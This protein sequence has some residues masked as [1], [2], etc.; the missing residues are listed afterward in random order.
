MERGGVTE[1]ELYVRDDLAVCILEAEDV[2]AYLETIDGDEAVEEGSATSPSSNTRASTST[3]R[4]NRSC[5]WSASGRS[6]TIRPRNRQQDLS[7]F[8]MTR[9]YGQTRD[10]EPDQP[11]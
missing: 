7:S 1:F 9:L 11:I 6:E 4:T 3:T 2:D 8:V 5:S 10:P